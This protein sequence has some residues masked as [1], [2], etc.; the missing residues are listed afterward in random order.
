MCLLL[1]SY[2]DTTNQLSFL[3]SIYFEMYSQTEAD[4]QNLILTDITNG[5]AKTEILYN[6]QGY[7][8]YRFPVKSDSKYIYPAVM[9]HFRTV[10]MDTDVTVRCTAWVKDG[11]RSPQDDG[12]IFSTEFTFKMYHNPAG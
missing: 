3:E 8:L 9:V 5:T 1:H 6:P 4:R 7:P 10:K 11:D 2:L 12:S